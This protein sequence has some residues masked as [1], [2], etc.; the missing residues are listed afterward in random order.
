VKARAGCSGA[1]LAAALG[2]GVALAPWVA[3]AAPEAPVYTIS[4]GQNEIP[5]ALRSGGNDALAALHYADDDAAAFHAFMRTMSRRAFL[6]SV[7]D[8]DT[9]RRYP[10]LVGEALVP[11]AAELGRVVGEVRRAMQEDRAAGREPVLV[12]FYSGHGVRDQAGAPGLALYDGA[13][14]QE[15][16]YDQV[17]GAVPAHIEHVI[18]DACHAEAVV[19]PRDAEAVV[20]TL[21]ADE[22]HRYMQTTTLARLPQVGALLA[23]TS[24]AESFEWDAYRGGVFAHEVLSGLRGA[25]DVNGDGR[26]EYSELAAFLA[27]AN[28]QISDARARPQIVVQPPR[29]DRRAPIVDLGRAEGLVRIA[30]RARGPWARPLYVETESG[31]RLADLFAERDGPIALRLPEGEP[32]YL[33]RPDGEIPLVLAGGA[34]ATI[35]LEGLPAAEPRARARGALDSAMRKGLFATAFG[36]AF[37]RGYVSQQQD[38]VPVD[39]PDD[40]PAAGLAARGSNGRAARTTGRILLGGAAVAGV[41]AGVFG[42]LALYAKSQYNATDVERTATD[43]RNRFYRD[44]LLGVATGAGAAALLG[45]G[46]AVLHWSH[47]ATETAAQ[48]QPARG[49]AFTGSGL[50]IVGEF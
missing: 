26:I 1:V 23:S 38:L 29:T 4:I 42:G 44:R 10:K 28:L 8:A 6:L 19:R 7:L 33:V 14:S 40:A 41:T 5:A 37:Y 18:V 48:P 17:L 24:G 45:A 15:K 22:L 27:A 31:V 49:I 43:A 20:E 36:P 25:A 46:L 12:L 2:A 3:R 47:G 21:P 34:G 39:F 16:L 32:V 13:L 11:T 30:G 35:S 50:A 9:Q